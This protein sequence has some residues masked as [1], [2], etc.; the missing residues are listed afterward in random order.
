MNR[1]VGMTDAASLDLE[2]IAETS[3]WAEG[4]PEFVELCRA[5]AGAA[6]AAARGHRQFPGGTAEA[7][8]LLSDDA[9]VRALNKTFRGRDESTNVL[10][11]SNV[12][13]DVLAAAGAD[14]PPSALGDIVIAFETTVGEAAREGKFL[15]DHLSHLVVHGI[16]HL[17]GYD[18]ST[19]GEALE[20]EA[21]E[22][23]ALSALGIADPYSSVGE[24]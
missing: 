8:L 22:V 16:L 12:E 6:F 2:V 14:G 17:L 15:N 10:S 1:N 11:F 4:L 24:A 23:C 19:D 5:A 3:A 9:R 18:H 7:C 21:L 13:V 20:M